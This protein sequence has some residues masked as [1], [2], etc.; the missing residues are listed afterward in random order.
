MERRYFI[1]GIGTEVGKT[2]VSA[3]LCEAWQAD[4]WKPVQ[5]GFPHDRDSE[6]VASLIT[7]PR[8]KIHPERFLLKQ[9][10]SPHVAADMEGVKVDTKTLK[11]PQTANTLL[12]EGAGGLM[13]PINNDGEMMID[14]VSHFQCA[15][16]LVSRHYLGSINHTLLSIEALRARN[17]HIAG[18]VF[19]GDPMPETER[20]ILE[21]GKVRC[22][23]RVP[24][25]KLVDAENIRAL[26]QTHRYEP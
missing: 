22:I 21:M 20:T 1:S 12:I 6:I 13:V 25:L 15:C 8:T 2:L 4:Y 11:L 10:L 24:H 3:L 16:I 23:G 14:L 19:T 5:S 9:P 17:I 18:V 26:T 7:N